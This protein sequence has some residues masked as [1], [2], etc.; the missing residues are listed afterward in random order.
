MC[1][2]WAQF[3]GCITRINNTQIDD[4]QHTDVAMS[5]YNLIKYSDNYSKTSGVLRQYCRDETTINIIINNNNNNNNNEF[6]DFIDAN[7]TN[8]F[9]LKVKL[10]VKTGDNGTKS[11]EIMA[12]LKYLSN[13]WRTLEMSLSNCEIIFDL[14]CSEKCVTM[15]TNITN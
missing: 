9:S 7:L 4:A 3:T 6:I 2:N 12:A 14:N 1:K 13:F 8:S 10:T 5:M 11:V 15:A